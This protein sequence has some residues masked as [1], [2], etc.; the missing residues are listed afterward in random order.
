MRPG[1]GETLRLG[2]EACAPAG[3]VGGAQRRRLLDYLRRT[4]A[5]GARRDQKREMERIKKQGTFDLDF[6]YNQV[7]WDGTS[8]NL[9][10][11]IP[12]AVVEFGNNK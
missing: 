8:G 7:P 2:I 5:K 4:D 6:E 1:L 9:V 3:E 12:D 11:T 10:R